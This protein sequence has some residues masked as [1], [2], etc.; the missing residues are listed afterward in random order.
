MNRSK[1]WRAVLFVAFC[2]ATSVRAQSLTIDW[3]SINGG[4][5]AST[6]GLYSVNGT[7]GQFGAG[8]SSGGNY[9]LE[10]GFWN[11]AVALQTPGAPTLSVIRSGGNV[12]LFW[13][14]DGSSFHLEQSGY[15][16]SPASWGA[17]VQSASTNSGTISVTVPATAGYQFFRLKRP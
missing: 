16:A 7:I 5:G 15:V 11:V 3:F 17:T 10:C 6:G 14:E 1:P 13:P 9:T 12:T 4:G 2:V 8:K